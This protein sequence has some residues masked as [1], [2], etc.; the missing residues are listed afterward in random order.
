[1]GLT[2]GQPAPSQLPA[3]EGRTNPDPSKPPRTDLL[4]DPLPPGVIAR[5]G[6]SRLWQPSVR[7]LAFSPDAKRLATVNDVD[8]RWFLRMWDVT[9]GN[10][11]WRI[12][13]PA[14][15]KIH[16]IPSPA[17]SPDSKA[18]ALGC[19]DKT[20][21]LWDTATG[22]ECGRLTGHEGFVT[23]VAFS[24]DGKVLASLDTDKTIR[25]W[26][27]DTGKERQQLREQGGQPRVLAFSADSKTLIAM[28]SSLRQPLTEIHTV[29]WTSTLWDV[30]TGKERPG[31]SFETINGYDH[32]LSPD[33]QHFAVLTEKDLKSI[34]LF[35]PMTGKELRRIEVEGPRLTD[36]VFSADSQRMLA[37][38]RNGMVRI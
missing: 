33:G 27:V 9:P 15:D 31:Q 29:I 19:P 16:G 13:L 30:A 18:V 22:R 24:P 14:P 17:F 12:E 26:D 20:L 6:T 10:E 8:S 32:A 11:L 35:D 36:I 21:R 3:A 28:R 5:L 37:A 23:E 38:D 34:R 7:R 25:L 4:G 2:L 1:L